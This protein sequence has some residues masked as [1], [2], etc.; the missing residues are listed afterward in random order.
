MDLHGIR[1][2]VERTAAAQSCLDHLTAHGHWRH[3][4]ADEAALERR[5]EL[6]HWNAAPTG[7]C[8]WSDM[9]SSEART[10]LKGQHIFIV[11]DLA[12]R[13]WF[14][15]L[16]YLVNGTVAP[17]EVADG[18]P[19]HKSRDGDACTWNPDRMARGGCEQQ[20][21]T[22]ESA[23][24][25]TSHLIPPAADDFGGWAHFK[26]SSPCFLRWYGW[27]AGTLINLTLNHPPASKAWWGR[28]TTRDVMTMLLREKL[29]YTSWAD[30]GVRISY[31]W[32]GVVRTS[33]S[34]KTQHARHIAQVASRVGNGAPPTLVIAAMGAYDSQWQ[35]ANEV[36]R[37]L[38]GLFEGITT[39]WPAAEAGS[40]LVLSAGP[41]SCARDKKYSVYMGSGT[42]HGS[43]RNLDNA[44]ALIPLARQAALNNSVLFV[45]TSYTQ[46]SVPPLRT[47]PC[48]YDLPLGVMA[49]T[50]VQIT[51]N[52]L[53]ATATRL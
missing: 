29:L 48:H 27:R 46:M 13:L 25:A 28:G 18:Y 33:G 51:L 50:L 32:K 47:S 24:M 41:S 42:R 23:P 38:S 10:L 3:D 1:A 45:D 44:S 34:Y 22:S 53:S 30:H 17:A 20:I 4:A 14:S 40:P 16:V 9:R 7:G 39:R 6:W 36:S 37:R 35:N 26:K 43:F 49:E 19:L 21:Q 2:S 31:L 5:D 11:G 52:A 12:A 8:S 15:A